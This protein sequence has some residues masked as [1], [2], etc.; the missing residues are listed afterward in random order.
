M[1]GNPSPAERL[2]WH[3]HSKPQWVADKVLYLNSF[4]GDRA[5]E[6]ICSMTLSCNLTED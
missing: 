5:S 2:V 4:L 6:S 1:V 3:K